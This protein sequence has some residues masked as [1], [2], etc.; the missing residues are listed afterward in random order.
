MR[1]ASWLMASANAGCLTIILIPLKAVKETPSVET[2]TDAAVEAKI[3][4]EVRVRI[5][6]G[7][8][9]RIDGTGVGGPRLLDGKHLIRSFCS[10]L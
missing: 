9:A 1:P 6:D 4:G 8:E 7:V 3:A 10:L 2:G 5:E